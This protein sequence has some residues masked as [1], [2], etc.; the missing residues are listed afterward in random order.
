MLTPFFYGLGY[1]RPKLYFKMWNN[2]S[3]LKYTL[4]LLY[5]YANIFVIGFKKMHLIITHKRHSKRQ[6]YCYGCPVVYRC[7]QVLEYE[8]STS[9]SDDNPFAGSNSQPTGKIY[10]KLP[11]DERVCQKMDKLNL[12]IDEG[13][14]P[15]EY[16]S[17]WTVQGP[18]CQDTTVAG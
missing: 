14:P 7:H 11:L 1:Q 10:V 16:R 9:S 12:N 6:H 2:C 5:K 15:Q 3:P 17:L 4:S 8:S 13:Y 18:V